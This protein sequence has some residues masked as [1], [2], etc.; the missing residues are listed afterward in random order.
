MSITVLV[1]EDD[2]LTRMMLRSTLERSGLEVVAVGRADEALVAAADQA[3]Q[4]AVL[5]VHLGIGPS[6]LDLAHELRRRQPDVGIVMLTSLLDPRLAGEGIVELPARARYLPK[7]AVTSV[8]MLLGVIRDVLVEVTTGTNP[9][10]RH[11]AAASDGPVELLAARWSRS[12]NAGARGLGA[13]TDSQMATLRLVAEGLTNAQIAERLSISPRTVE[14]TVLRIARVL[15]LDPDGSRN[16]RV[17]LAGV[18]F[19]GLR[20]GA[21]P[22]EAADPVQGPDPGPD[23]P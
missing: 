19:R 8:E 2:P 21:E 3:L 1:V 22:P 11:H 16:Q 12:R 23:A 10:G 13:L 9:A 17:H 7:S 20:G 6:G 14:K 4:V 15:S 18:Y 5:D